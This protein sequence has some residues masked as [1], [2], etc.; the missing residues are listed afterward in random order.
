MRRPGGYRKS[1]AA[2]LNVGAGTGGGRRKLGNLGGKVGAAR[3]TLARRGKRRCKFGASC[4]AA[5]AAWERQKS[6]GNFAATLRD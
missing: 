1:P 6:G 5:L 3:R 2:G 4:P